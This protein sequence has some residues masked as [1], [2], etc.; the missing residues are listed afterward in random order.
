M[1]AVEKPAPALKH[2]WHS[3]DEADGQL[4]GSRLLGRHWPE[5]ERVTGGGRGVVV[6]RTGK[7]R[8]RAAKNMGGWRAAASWCLLLLWLT[9]SE[10]LSHYC[11]LCFWV[12]FSFFW[13]HVEKSCI[14][15]ECLQLNPPACP[16]ALNADVFRNIV[17]FISLFVFWKKQKL[18]ML[19]FQ[20]KV[21]N[22]F[23]H[24]SSEWRCQWKICHRYWQTGRWLV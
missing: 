13:V 5:R 22:F 6:R 18:N 14:L 20:R 9:F 24:W 7:R 21:C 11:R 8:V 19:L 12:F 10:A 1:T 23:F 3:F 15:K 16:H 17:K 2:D 4:Q